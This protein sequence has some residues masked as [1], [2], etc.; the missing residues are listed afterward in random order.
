M[1][2]GVGV[3]A[4]RG[5]VGEDW[6]RARELSDGI[7]YPVCGAS[8]ALVARFREH[9]QLRF[10]GFQSTGTMWWPSAQ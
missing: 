1:R 5:L 10:Q 7:W 2:A 8:P 3:A 6:V 4:A 9:G